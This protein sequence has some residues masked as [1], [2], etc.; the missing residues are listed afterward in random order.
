LFFV[1]CQNFFFLTMRIISLFTALLLVFSAMQLFAQRQCAAEDVL[2]QH[3]LENPILKQ[4]LEAIER[5]TEEYIAAGGVRERMVVTIPVVVNV[6]WNTAAENI[7]D[8]QI[9]SQIAVLNDDFRRLNADKV[10]TPSAFSGLAADLEINFCLATR[11]PSGNATT[12]IRRQ[13]TTVTAFGTN[14]AM[15][16]TAQGGLDGWSRDQ[17]LNFWVCDISGGILGYAQ[18]PGTGLAAT[19]GVVCDYQYVGTI[20][21]ATAP[22]NKGRTATHEVGHWLN[23]YHIWGDDGTSCSGS[24][25]VA[26]TPNQ[27]DEHY[28]C[29]VFPQLSCSSGPNGDMFMNYMDYTDDACMNMFT[30]GQKAR[31]QALF[32]AGGA[33]AA[34]LNSLGCSAPGG[35]T[36]AVTSGLNATSVASTTATVNWGAATGAVTYNL[37]YKLSTSATWTTITGIT[38]TTRNLTGLTASSTYNY[39]VQTVCSST[40]AAYSTAASFT[41]TAGSGGCTDNYEPNETRTTAVVIPA[42]T[43]ITAKIATATDKDYFRFSNTAATSRIKVDLT[44]LP[45]DYDLKLYRSS[46]LLGTSENAGTASE[47][48]IVNTTTVSSNYVAYVY[49]YNGASNAACYNLRVSLSTSNWRTDGSTDGEQTQMEIPVIFENAGFG[50]F[51]NP[52]K[53]MVMIEVPVEAESDVQVSVMDAS[54]RVAV[55]ENR[56]M[57]KGNNQVQVDLARLS[58]GI[59]F[60]QVRNGDTI[61][62]RKL[63]VQQ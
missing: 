27:A 37:Q 4:Q 28:G 7:S 30:A 42:N 50:M 16:Y 43:T 10:N 14:D 45:N 48:L 47:Q 61:N 40:S 60:V 3:L 59:Y 46:T 31:A 62:T 51:P 9:L 35:G 49:G 36:C 29:P 52:A 26:D 56:V 23:L 24:D 55:Q 41:T 1:C 6:V 2:H 21:T 54:G 18:F 8:A 38:G 33:R 15:K 19:D 20:G 57:S 22:F 5:H 13:Q 44:N 34:L 58:T 11:D 63:V 39:Q 12:G 32:A 17:Y 25:L 53:D